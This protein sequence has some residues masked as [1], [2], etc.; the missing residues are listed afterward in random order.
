MM[1]GLTEGSLGAL[2][3]HT[4]VGTAVWDRLVVALQAMCVEGGLGAMLV[5]KG[6]PAP[7]RGVGGSAPQG[8]RMEAGS[9]SMTDKPQ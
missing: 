9:M 2:V 1:R 3:G 7:W 5:E 6:D 8:R 4:A